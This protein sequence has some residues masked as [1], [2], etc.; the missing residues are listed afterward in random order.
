M[1]ILDILLLIMTGVCITYCWILN[2]RIHDLQNSRIEFARMIKELNASIIKAENNVSEM[3]KLSNLASTEIKTAINEA[4]EISSELVMISETAN[5]LYTNLFIQ[6]NK[7]Q[8]ADGSD[9]LNSERSEQNSYNNISSKA[10]EKFTEDDL[11]PLSD[12]E[13]VTYTN[14]LKNFIQNIVTTKPDKQNTSLNQTSY[15]NTLRK[16]SAKK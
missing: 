10:G 6:S 12:N 3:S 15:Y 14:H 2:R 9:I 8:N 16:I 5:E 4:K 7:I 1:I 13:G 11:A